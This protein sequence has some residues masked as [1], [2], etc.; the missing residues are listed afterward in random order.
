MKPKNLLTQLT[1]LEEALSN[2]SFEEL[3][4]EDARHLR[5]S[6]NIFRDQ[7]ER[8]FLGMPEE[9]DHAIAQK[10]VLDATFRDEHQEGSLIATVSHEIRTPLSGIVGFADL[11]QESKLT[12]LQQEHVKAIRSA[13]KSLMDIINELLE[14]SRL[15]AGM[16][17]Y[18]YVNFN[19]DGVLEDVTTLCQNLMKEKDIEFRVD[20][21][22]QI[23]EY[24]MGDP[25]KLSQILLNLISNSI[26]FVDKGHIKLNISLVGQRESQFRLEFVIS[27]TGIGISE[28]DIK[29]IFD[30]YR[31]ANQKIF[32][33]YGGTGL[34]LHIVKQI[35]NRLNGELEVSSRVGVGTT[36]RC[37]LDYAQGKKTVDV[38]NIEKTTSAES[39]KDLKILVFEDNLLNQRLIEQRLKYWG[40]QARITDNP[41]LGLKLLENEAIDLVLMDLRMPVM[42]GFEVT[43]Q[44]RNSQSSRVRQIPVIAL[45]ADFTI[46][47]QNA[48]RAGGIN[49]YLLKPFSPEELLEKISSVLQ[50]ASHQKPGEESQ[51]PKRDLA[52]MHT[53][54]VNLK[55]ALEDCM[56][57]LKML[58]ELIELFKGNILE[59]IGRTKIHLEN[60][61]LEKIGDAAHKVKCGLAMLQAHSLH[62]I[63]EQIQNI[64]R[65]ERDLVQLRKLYESFIVSYPQVEEAMDKQLTS[66]G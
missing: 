29:C 65:H 60:A 24:L 25:S 62:R 9:P 31:Q 63:V 15:S 41:L 3:T 46:E 58:G 7:L 1:N 36:F 43:Q 64:C 37:T 20:R 26:K 30:S 12:D 42:N 56:G 23:P 39:I 50:E 61:D 27:D 53:G 34:G 11:L 38:S 4:I 17:N 40:C 5:N 51:Y 66:M 21:D 28:D 18:R 49:D 44:I 55:P 14:Y 2:F 59:F 35:V 16:D 54:L 22:P 8:K 19:F 57:D 47:D 52:V 10:D 32:S 48:C 13:S 6:F 45:T 33:K